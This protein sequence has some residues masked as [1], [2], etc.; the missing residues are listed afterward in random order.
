[1]NRPATLYNRKAFI[2]CVLAVWVC[3]VTAL[4]A[5]ALMLRG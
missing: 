5:W 2:A 3:V 4:G 1:M